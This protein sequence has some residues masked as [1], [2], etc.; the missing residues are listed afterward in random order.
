MIHRPI[1]ILTQAD[2]VFHRNRIDMRIKLVR[3]NGL[4]QV[5]YCTFDFIVL[6]TKFPSRLIYPAVLH[7]NEFVEGKGRAFLRKIN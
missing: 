5:F 2:N 7:F 3:T 1:V 6:V 4:K